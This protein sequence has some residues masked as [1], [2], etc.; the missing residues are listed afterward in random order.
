MI[1]YPSNVHTEFIL[2][3]SYL[4]SIGTLVH[5]VVNIIVFM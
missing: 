2:V 1:K 4:Y 5:I 3:I